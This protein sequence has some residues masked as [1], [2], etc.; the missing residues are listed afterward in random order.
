MR[1]TTKETT[2]KAQ[3]MIKITRKSGDAWIT[4]SI[5]EAQATAELE[6]L[7]RHLRRTKML[8][9]GRHGIARKSTIAGYENAIARREHE[10]GI[11]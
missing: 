5:T 1:T 6:N 8:K 11:N 4:E 3:R 9:T 7:R 2:M 10:L